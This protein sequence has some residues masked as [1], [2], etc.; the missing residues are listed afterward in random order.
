MDSID[1]RPDPPID[2]E[3]M[4]ATTGQEVVEMCEAEIIKIKGDEAGAPKQDIL[5]DDAI[6]ACTVVLWKEKC[7]LL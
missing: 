7:I 1:L 4:S 5:V 2:V 3:D 6:G